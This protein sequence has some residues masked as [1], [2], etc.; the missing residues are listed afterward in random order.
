[1]RRKMHL[2]MIEFDHRVVNRV[3]DHRVV[4]RVFDHRV[5]TVCLFIVL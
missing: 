2:L 5:V 3:S 1:M 4:T